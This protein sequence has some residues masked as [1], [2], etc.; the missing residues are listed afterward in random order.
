MNLSTLVIRYRQQ[1]YQAGKV[2]FQNCEM[3]T[4]SFLKQSKQAL[5]TP[6]HLILQENHILTFLRSLKI[7]RRHSLG[8][9][10]GKLFK[11]KVVFSI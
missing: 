2:T 6:K 7:H 8:D 4:K 11:M 3:G 5:K 10:I 1:L 9:Y